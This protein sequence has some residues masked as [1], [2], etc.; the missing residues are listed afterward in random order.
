MRWLLFLSRLAFICGIC[1][2][3]SLSLLIEDWAKDEDITGTLITIGFVMGLIVVPVTLLCYLGVI[4]L[5]KNLTVPVW[6]VVSNILFL[7][8]LLFYII[9]I[10]GH[11]PPPA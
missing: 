1:F 7:F 6:L 8:V 4:I 11:Q 2:V 5:K 9:F 3:L 10:N